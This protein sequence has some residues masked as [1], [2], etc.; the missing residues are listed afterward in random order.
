MLPISSSPLHKGLHK[1][2]ELFRT[3][4]EGM[5]NA[6]GE[7]EKKKVIKLFEKAGFYLYIHKDSSTHTHIRTHTC[8]HAPPPPPPHAYAR[9]HARTHTHTHTH[10]HTYAHT[11]TLKQEAR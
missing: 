1:L 2:P 3:R 11:L 8:T 7:G 10:I 9:T 4:G 6:G 5:R